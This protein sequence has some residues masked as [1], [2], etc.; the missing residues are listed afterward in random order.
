MPEHR[1]TSTDV[2]L[3]HRAWSAPCHRTCR[4]PTTGER[5]RSKSRLPGR[6]LLPSTTLEHV[7]ALR[8]SRTFDRSAHPYFRRDARDPPDL[9]AD[10]PD[11]HQSLRPGRQAGFPL[12]GLS[13]DRPSIVQAAESDSRRPLRCVSAVPRCAFEA[14]TPIPAR[15]P[16]ARFFTTSAVF[17]LDPASIFQ[18]AADPRVHHVSSCRETGFPAMHL[19][20][21]EAFPPPTATNS[22]INLDARGPASPPRSSLTTAFTANLAPSSFSF[23]L[24][25]GRFPVTSVWLKPGPRGLAPSSG[26]LPARPLPA[27]RA[28]CSLGLGR[29]ARFS[30][31]FPTRPPRAG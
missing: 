22:E 2:A 20:P 11:A 15:V 16:P 4:K 28:R 21:F 19:L 26:P 27:A 13:K 9:G 30:S 23:S 29:I 14:G 18:A 3:S 5:F 31:P 24:P 10:F 12:L 7:A 8:P 1:S 6:S 25:S 17:L